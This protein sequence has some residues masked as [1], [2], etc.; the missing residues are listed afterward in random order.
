MTGSEKHEG[1]GQHAEFEYRTVEIDEEL[2]DVLNEYG[3]DGW[4]FVDAVDGEAVFERI[5]EPAV[6]RTIAKRDDDGEET[7]G[8]AGLLTR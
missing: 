5:A 7:K 8:L 4:R 2:E 6:V 1:E 3:D